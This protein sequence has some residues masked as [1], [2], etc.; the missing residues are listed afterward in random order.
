MSEQEYIE[1]VG[2][3]PPVDDTD[4]RWQWEYQGSRAEREDLLERL[5]AC[6]Q[7]PDEPPA[8]QETLW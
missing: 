4:E 7:L 6:A 5:R 8:D 3:P 2:H 1:N